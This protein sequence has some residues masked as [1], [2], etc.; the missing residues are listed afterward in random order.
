MTRRELTERTMGRAAPG[1]FSA[2]SDAR[3]LS[4]SP[5]VASDFAAV[6]RGAGPRPCFASSFCLVGGAC[7]SEGFGF[8][9]VLGLDFSAGLD[10]SLGFSWVA[11]FSADGFVFVG[12]SA[13]AFVFAGRS[14]EHTSELQ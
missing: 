3:D 12:F 13:G 11:C 10:F 7:L 2:G 4:S 5:G 6:G 1:G 9:G 14:E 8:P